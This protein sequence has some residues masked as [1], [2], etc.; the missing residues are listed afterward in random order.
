MNIHFLY[1]LFIT[2]TF[3]FVLLTSCI[4]EIHPDLRTVS[5][6]LVVEGAITTDSVPYQVRL[7]FSG[8]YQFGAFVPDTLLIVDAVVTIKDNTG[9]QSA[10]SYSGNGIYKTV[11]N[12][13]IG[14][15]EK[16]YQVE[17]KLKDGREYI[18]IPETIVQPVPIASISKVEFDY[19]AYDFQKPTDFKIFVDVDDP[20]S[21][22]N[23]Y[24]WEGYSWV[25]RKAT[26]VPCGIQCIKWQYCNQRIERKYLH[27]FSD[28]AING[29]RIV[30]RLV[31]RSPIYWFGKHYVDIGQ[32]SM[33]REAFQFWKRFEEQ[34]T[35]TGS[36]LD[37]LPSPIE[38]NVYNVND[39]DDLAL[40]YFSASGVSHKRVV[41][42]PYNISQ[43]LLDQTA[44]TFIKEGGCHLVFPNAL[45]E[46]QIPAGWENAEEIRVE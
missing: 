22:Q 36:I 7:T 46:P 10:M 18:S 5:P 39:P 20:S 38:G 4:K 19:S 21:Q 23:F 31:Y 44:R 12:S 30:Q 17:I 11:D 40:G 43:F 9:R 32:L 3:A 34:S 41:L 16:S 29:N 27:Y 13:F 26:G 25:P 1:N 42:V 2:A 37:P 33:T 6:K 8:P 24:R 14:T 28:A 15:P 35:K 45:E